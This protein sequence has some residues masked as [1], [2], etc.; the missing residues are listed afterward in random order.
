MEDSLIVSQPLDQNPALVY[1]AG[2]ASERSRETQLDSLKVI[3]R[4]LGGDVLTVNWAALRFQHTALVK[5]KLTESYS[6]AATNRMLSALRG[7]LKAAWRLGQMQ[8]DDYSKA[9][10]VSNV[11][12]SPLLRGRALSSGEINAL[13]DACWNDDSPAGIRDAAIFAVFYPGG[14]RRD[15]VRKLD[16]SDWDSETGALTVAHGKGNKARLAYITNGAK[17]ALQDWVEYRGERPGPLFF[18]INKGGTTQPHRITSQAI[19]AIVQKRG[20]EAGIAHF[21]AHDLRRTFVSDLLDLGADVSL[22]AGLAGH[23]SVTT[24]AKYDRRPTEA[25]KKAANLIHV[26]YRRTTPR[27]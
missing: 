7:T 3:A 4:I 11:K 19:H 2:L 9:A 18:A 13:F 12:A 1:L 20:K 22:V 21:S 16:F 5:S 8:I 25:R 23:S 14:L 27:S 6:P 15:E 17:Q 26:G 24:T 10:D